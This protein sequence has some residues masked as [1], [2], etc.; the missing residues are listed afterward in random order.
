M[1]GIYKGIERFKNRKRSAKRFA[2]KRGAL[3]SH[4][5]KPNR[6]RRGI[7]ST[8]LCAPKACWV[9]G[10]HITRSIK[11]LTQTHPF[12]AYLTQPKKI[13]INQ[14]ASVVP[15]GV[16]PGPHSVQPQVEQGQPSWHLHLVW[17]LQAALAGA[18]VLAIMM[19]GGLSLVG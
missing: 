12:F 1:E 11:H 13:W 15:P 3:P 16:A 14:E 17:S 7:G 4:K 10:F 6:P 5:L 8:L 9:K 18:H 19:I 2:T